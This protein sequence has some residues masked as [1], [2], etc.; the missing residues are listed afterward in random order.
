[1]LAA[2]VVAVFLIPVTFYV[3]ERLAGK[4]RTK[5]G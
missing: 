2:T 4:K 3:V 5:E 1:M